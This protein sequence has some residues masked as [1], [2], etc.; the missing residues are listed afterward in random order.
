METIKVNKEKLIEKLKENKIKHIEEYEKALLG[1]KINV[2]KALRDKIKELK[3][4]PALQIGEF[5]LN[6]YNL[7]KPESHEYDF[8]TVIG[9]LEVSEDTVVNID[10]EEYKRYYMNEWEWKKS[11]GLTHYTNIKAGASAYETLYNVPG[12][13]NAVSN[14]LKK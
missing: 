7:H 1:Y 5:N 4:L 12:V 8:N 11:W 13:G 6:F 3:K 2:E 14:T 10:S 9:M